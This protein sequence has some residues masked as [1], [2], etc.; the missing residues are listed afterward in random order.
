MRSTAKRTA[1]RATITALS[2][3]VAWVA[4]FAA[5]RAEPARPSRSLAELKRALVEGT[6]GDRQQAAL[7]VSTR[8]D[9]PLAERADALVEALEQE[10]AQPTSRDFLTYSP[11]TE[12]LKCHYSHLAFTRMGGAAIPELVRLGQG[13][14]LGVRLRLL[15]SRAILGDERALASLVTALQQST[16][17]WDRDYLTWVFNRCPYPPAAPEITRV[18]REGG[19]VLWPAGVRGPGADPRW[20]YGQEGAFALQRLGMAIQ[21]NNGEYWNVEDPKKPVLFLPRVPEQTLS[22][23]VMYLGGTMKDAEGKPVQA[24]VVLLPGQHLLLPASLLRRLGVDA[25]EEGEKVR[26]GE[27]VRDWTWEPS[28]ARLLRQPAGIPKFVEPAARTID[29]ELYVPAT[30]VHRTVFSAIEWEAPARR[31]WFWD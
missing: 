21:Q 22:V 18:L 8:T 14:P 30:A 26:F 12:V 4:A 23:S 27:G 11:Q 28:T 9:I 19:W 25:T 5:A 1:S 3:A 10:I 31:L 13:K 7:D 2:V 16:D 17:P 24:Q 6:Y 29:G 15:A 20:F